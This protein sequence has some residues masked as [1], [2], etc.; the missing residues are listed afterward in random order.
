MGAFVF[1]GLGLSVPFTHGV[2]IV[3]HSARIAHGT[4]VV[5]D[6]AQ[7]LIIGTSIQITDRLIHHVEAGGYTDWLK[8]GEQ[9]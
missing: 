7:G 8:D 5:K 2:Y 1:P 4:A 3:W 9:L 6:P